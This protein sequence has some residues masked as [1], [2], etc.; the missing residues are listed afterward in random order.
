MH[1]MSLVEYVNEKI[2][3]VALFEGPTEE[4]QEK[5][6]ENNIFKYPPRY[7]LV[8]DLNIPEGSVIYVKNILYPGER[9]ENDA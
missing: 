2:G 5:V 6:F 4:L 8:D 7:T 1:L 3:E 9:D